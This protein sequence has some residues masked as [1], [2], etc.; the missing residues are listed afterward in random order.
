MLPFF[1]LRTDIDKIISINSFPDSQ[2]AAL[3]NQDKLLKLTNE[4]TSL[5]KLLKIEQINVAGKQITRVLV[6]PLA[7]NKEAL[8]VRN[9]LKQKLRDHPE[10]IVKKY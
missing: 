5:T 6:G 9:N 2:L 1:R 4:V 8:S 7:S 10:G 3:Q